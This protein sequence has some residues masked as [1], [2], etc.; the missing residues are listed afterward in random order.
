[1]DGGVAVSG[2]GGEGYGEEE[3]FNVGVTE[4]GFLSFAAEKCDLKHNLA[5]WQGYALIGRDYSAGP[6]VLGFLP[7]EPEGFPCLTDCAGDGLP[8]AATP[9]W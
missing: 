9:R 8:F 1:M 7:R 2:L 4:K 3:I 5:V 6:R